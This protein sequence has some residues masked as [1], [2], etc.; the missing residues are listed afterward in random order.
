MGGAAILAAL[1]LIPAELPPQSRAPATDL[2]AA[3]EV[4]EAV[5]SLL[6]TSCYDCHSVETRYP[7]YSHIAPVSWL[8]A[9]D[10]RDG[11]E[12]LN[13][14][15]WS[16]LAKRKKVKNLENIKEEVLEE[17]MP[18]P[19]Y[20]VIHWDAR[21]TDAQRQQIADWANAYQDRIMQEPDPEEEDEEV[22]DE[23]EGQ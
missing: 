2:L 7:W 5:A 16:D 11:R 4:P 17:H 21:L 19:I 13:L 3:A 10:V 14:S 6:K 23:E 20:L 8:V 18:M 1:Q 22:E 9:R 15:G 12:E